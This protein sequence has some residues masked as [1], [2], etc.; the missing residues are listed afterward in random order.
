MDWTPGILRFVSVCVGNGFGVGTDCFEVVFDIF[1]V[2]AAWDTF[3]E[4][5]AGASYWAELDLVLSKGLVV[6]DTDTNPME[7]RW[8]E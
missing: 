3:E 8:L 1:E 2:D 4:D 6:W 5:S 7:S